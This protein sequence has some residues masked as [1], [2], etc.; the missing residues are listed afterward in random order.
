[1]VGATSASSATCSSLSARKLFLISCH[2]IPIT[3]IASVAS[4]N[5]AAYSLIVI[6]LIVIALIAI[7][8]IIVV[9]L[10]IRTISI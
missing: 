10:R 5:R 4:N 1:M 6:A 2:V 8:L 7:A 9:I 3:T